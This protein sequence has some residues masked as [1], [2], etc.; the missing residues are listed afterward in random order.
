[1][2][3]L[4]IRKGTSQ[5]RDPELAAQQLHEAIWQPDIGLAVFYCAADFDLP[6]LA[7][8]LHRRFGDV[9]LVGCTTAG[10]ITPQGYLTGSLTGFSMAAPGL[11]VATALLPLRPF[12]ADAT[13][14]A[15]TWLLA[16]LGTR[17]GLPASATDTFAFLL[18]DG[19]AMQEE[20]VVSC[21]HQQL[22]GIDLIGGSAADDTRFGATHVYH[23][24][25]FHQ[26]VALLNLVRTGLPFVTFRTQHFVHSDKRMVVTKADAANRVVHQINGRPAAREFARL[27]GLPLTE[28]TPMIFA[29]HPVVVRVGGQY[30]VRSIARVNPDESLTFFCAIDEGIVLTIARGVDMVANL[31]KAFDDVRTEI[32]QPQLVLGYDCILRRLETEREGIKDRI[33]QIFADNNVIGFAT[34]GEQFNSMHVNQTFTGIAIGGA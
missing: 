27:V 33:G 6:A 18:I 17:D 26:Q 5:H 24:G 25:R 8:A 21:I 15:V 1:M 3:K 32:G 23:G 2:S 13:T 22:G 4:S 19:L 7:A 10:E 20:L 11:D 31:Q 16:D 34:Y 14:A 12:D 30:Y 29:T 28:L 9:N